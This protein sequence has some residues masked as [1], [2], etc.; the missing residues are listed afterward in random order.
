MGHAVPIHYVVYL[1]QHVQYRCVSTQ[2]YSMCII[3]HSAIACVYIVHSAIACIYS[4]QRYSMCIYNYTDTDELEVMYVS[5]CYHMQ[6]LVIYRATLSA[7]YRVPCMMAEDDAC[8]CRRV[9][10]GSSLNVICR[11]MYIPVILGLCIIVW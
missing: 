1:A 3:V 8:T 6:E 7:M 10:G 11:E 2:R 9:V 5:A 4:T